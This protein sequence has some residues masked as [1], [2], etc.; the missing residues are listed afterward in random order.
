MFLVDRLELEDQADKA[1]KNICERLQM[2]YLSKRTE[3]IG[4][5]PKLLF[6][7]F[8]HFYLRTNTK[9]LFAPTDFD[10]VISDEAHRSIEA[11]VEQ[12]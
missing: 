8:N 6:Q 3:T 1:L 10:L 9:R 5:N 7:P 2:Y 12:F 4:E 11:T